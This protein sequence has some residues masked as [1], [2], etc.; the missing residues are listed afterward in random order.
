MPHINLVRLADDLRAAY[1]EGGCPWGFTVADEI[2]A[3]ASSPAGLGVSVVIAP[4]IH[5]LEAVAYELTTAA[6]GGRP[7]VVLKETM[8]LRS[9]WEPTDRAADEWDG[10]L[11]WASSVL[12][13]S[14]AHLARRKA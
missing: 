14:E 4:T 1:G 13:F 6:V 8:V 2:A 10:A 3:V 7:G 9:A 11:L 12:T 5:G